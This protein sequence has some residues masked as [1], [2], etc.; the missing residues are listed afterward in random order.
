VPVISVRGADPAEHEHLAELYGAWGYQAKISGADTMYVAERDT[1]IVGLVR[2]ACEEGATMLRG[3][4]VDPAH[5]R[6]GVGSRLLDVFAED[7]AGAECLCVPY[8]HLTTFYGRVGFVVVD[9]GAAPA[10]L[11]ERVQ[12]YRQEGKDVLIMRRRPPSHDRPGSLNASR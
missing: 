9:E 10:F 5:Q 7:L 3:M 12:R 8:A 2:R 4:Q 11:V 6:Q 1:R